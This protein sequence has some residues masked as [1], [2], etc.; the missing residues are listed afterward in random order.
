MQPSRRGTEREVFGPRF[1]MNCGTALPAQSRFCA[2]CGTQLRMPAAAGPLPVRARADVRADA[3][4]RHPW[5]HNSANAI[6]TVFGLIVLFSLCNAV[7]VRAPVQQ[8]IPSSSASPQPTASGSLQPVALSPVIVGMTTVDIEGNLESRGFT[9]G[10]PKAA[11]APDGAAMEIV[12][13]LSADDGFVYDVSYA[14]ETS[15]RVRAL[16]ASIT[17]A[18][19]TA[20]S[21][22]DQS[23]AVFLGFIATLPYTDAQ[24]S[25]AQNWVKNNVTKLGS[26]ITIATAFFQIDPSPSD[27]GARRLNIVAVGAR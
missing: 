5:V 25:D 7:L 18:T 4:M 16:T 9:C 21:I 11:Q 27:L 19:R 26:N 15:T 12:D 3:G 17:P 8:S 2:M 13:C 22:L 23:A 10:A 24:P 20:R 1:C 14:S 6:V